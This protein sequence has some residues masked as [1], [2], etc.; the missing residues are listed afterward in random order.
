MSLGTA[1]K[2][3]VSEIN[4]VTKFKGA[5]SLTDWFHGVLPSRVDEL[6]LISPSKNF[7]NRVRVY[8]L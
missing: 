2:S 8:F 1:G 5:G 7:K 6:S 3:A 4:K